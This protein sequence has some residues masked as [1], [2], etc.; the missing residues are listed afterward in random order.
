MQLHE[1]QCGF[2]PGRGTVDAIFV[3][4]QL[5][6]MCK[7]AQGAPLFSA[8]IDLTKAYDSVNRQAL[9]R[10]L[11]EYGVPAKLVALLEDL[12]TGTMSAV[13]MDGQVGEWFG[14]HVGVRQ[15]C[16]IAP[17]LFNTFMDFVVRHALAQMRADCETCGVHVLAG[18][19]QYS[20]AALLYADDLVLNAHDP[21][22]L[23]RM[24]A[25]MDQVA[26]KLGLTINASKTEMMQVGGV[27]GSA[28]PVGLS[29]GTAKVVDKFRY[30]GSWVDGSA[31]AQREVGVRVGQALASFRSLAGVWANKH[32]H[33]K[34]KVDVYRACVVSKFLYGAE[35]WNCTK[36]QVAR[37]EA[38]H[39]SCIRQLLGVSWRD[40]H[41]CEHLRS[42]CQLP[43]MELLLAKHR[44]R[45]VGHVCRMQPERLPRV[46]LEGKLAAASR[47]RRGR[48][49][50]S[51]HKV[52][53]STLSE[54]DVPFHNLANLS[55][56]AAD[57][58]GY[59]RML[60]GLQLRPKLPAAPTRVQPSRAC[61][62]RGGS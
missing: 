45:W 44:L 36:S 31:S 19:V 20:L 10:V 29:S 27:A 41:S 23:A 9:W 39:S 12:H 46:L 37:L 40:R 60:M 11:H 57:R 3:M 55:E 50:Q 13:R 49:A 17:L 42:Q 21:A 1:A 15:G 18:G 43:P 47:S 32:L 7:A 61:R 51:F 5:M 2:R 28:Q 8:F 6:S 59:R 62:H 48:P 14:T 25:T 56:H 26:G 33:L 54:Y 16:V 30:L 58:A 34:H 38:A 22:E 24:L 52:L 35:T 4:R 53:L